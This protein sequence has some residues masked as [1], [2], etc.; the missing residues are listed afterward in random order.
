[1]D[2]RPSTAARTEAEFDRLRPYLRRVAYS[3]LG[4]LSEAED[5]IQEAWLRLNRV[6]RGEIRDLRSWLFV[7]PARG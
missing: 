5:L 3:H 1:M 7:P 4:S 6:D 2:A